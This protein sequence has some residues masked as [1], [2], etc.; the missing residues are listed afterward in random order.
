M[1][2]PKCGF[3][4]PEGDIECIRCGIIFAKFKAY[5]QV[6]GSSRVSDYRYKIPVQEELEPQEIEREGWVALGLG[7]I[8]AGVVLI[9]PGLTSLFSYFITLVHELGHSLFAWIFGYPSIPAFDFTYGGGV[10]ITFGEKKI[11]ILLLIYLAFGGLF[12]Y[13]R[14]NR[15]SLIFLSGSFGLYTLFLLTELHEI[16]GLFMGHGTELVF[17]GIFLYRAISGFACIYPVERPLY[18]FIGFFTIFYNLRFSYQ[19]WMNPVYRAEY[20]EAKGG[21]DWM[22]FSRIARDYLQIEVS[23]VAAFF[24]FCC[25]LPF[26]LSFVVFRYQAYVSSFVLSILEK[27]PD[28]A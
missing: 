26:L 4:Q 21:G 3:E 11:W 13:Y 19:L 7:L 17:A 27:E 10:T 18:A 28:E 16:L 2:C 24:F 9:F 8:L 23:T 5:P 1:N 6:E 14:K 20:A 15:L 22:D 25:F 12:Y